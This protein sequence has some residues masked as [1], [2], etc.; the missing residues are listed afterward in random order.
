MKA[1]PSLVAFTTNPG[2]PPQ[3][4]L[5][6]WGAWAARFGAGEF[7]VLL[8]STGP[9]AQLY[10]LCRKALAPAEQAIPG[11]SYGSSSVVYDNAPVYRQ[12]LAP[13][14]GSHP[15]AISTLAG[16]CL[17]VALFT[18]VAATVADL[19]AV[20]EVVHTAAGEGSAGPGVLPGAQHLRPGSGSGRLYVHSAARSTQPAR[21]DKRA[22]APSKAP[23][24]R[25][26][27]R[28]SRGGGDL[29][30]NAPAGSSTDG[31]PLTCAEHS[32]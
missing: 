2:R 4:A 10:Q 21:V 18:A 14:A 31:L 26:R 12:Y 6:A 20:H 28:G 3:G 22:R 8:R 29:L 27:G 13:S 16:E 17:L 23:Y 19:N 1:G 15:C 24:R 32:P 30:H 9:F 7:F 25:S 11:V 5:H